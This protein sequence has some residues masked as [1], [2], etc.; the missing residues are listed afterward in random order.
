MPLH[1]F[2]RA[3]LEA[4]ALVVISLRNLEKGGKPVV[5]IELL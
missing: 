1:A 4:I 3:S 5:S 2:Y